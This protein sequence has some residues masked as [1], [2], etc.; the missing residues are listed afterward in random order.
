VSGPRDPQAAVVI[1]SWN[2]RDDLPSCLRSLETVT[3]PLEVVVVDNASSDG[4]A[5]AARE[6]SPRVRVLEAGSNHGFARAANLGWRATTASYVLFLNPDAELTSGALE[7]LQAV[8][9]A[10]PEVGIVGPATCNAD[11]TP[12]V[13]F[14]PDLT[15]WNEWRQRRLVRGVRARDPRALADVEA[16]SAREHEPAWVSGSCLLARRTLLERLGGFDE[17]FFLYEEDVDLCLRARQ[18]GLRIV[19]TPAARIVHRLGQSMEKDS[20]RARIEYDRSHLLYYR[21]Q[22]GTLL[23]GL[24][25]LY[26]AAAGLVSLL[27]VRSGRD[28]AAGGSIARAR[29][30]LATFGR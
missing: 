20:V 5:A 19:F 4:S 6:A 22:N 18:A 11:G 15:P 2:S 25:R 9:E 27:P 28:R 17:R 7:A 8:L 23:T 3:V 29:L 26:L 14:G 21:K 16:L 13:S 1:V 10:R 12:Q 24:L 30:R